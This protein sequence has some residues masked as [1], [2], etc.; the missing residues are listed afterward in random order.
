[1]HKP[2]IPHRSKGLNAEARHNEYVMAQL[3]VRPVGLGASMAA[4][5]QEA[6][7]TMQQNPFFIVAAIVSVLFGLA[8]LFIPD[9]VAGWYGIAVTD[10][11]RLMAQFCGSS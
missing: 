8:F 7:A 4:R 9:A 10:A 2:I 5:P 1:M 3:A 6:E 11:S